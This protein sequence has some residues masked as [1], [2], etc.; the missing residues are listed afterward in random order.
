M[1]CYYEGEPERR[2]FIKRMKRNLDDKGLLVV[3]A[4]RLLDQVRVIKTNEYLSTVELEEIRRK[5]NN[6]DNEEIQVD[7]QQDSNLSEQGNVETSEQEK[8]GQ[9]KV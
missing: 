9:L 5:I 4:Q 6:R 8:P 7:E 3:S 2:G 1:E